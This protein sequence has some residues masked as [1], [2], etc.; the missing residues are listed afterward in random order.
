M[1][2]WFCLFLSVF[3]LAG[4]LA[5]T[6]ARAFAPHMQ[7]PLHTQHDCCP[8]MTGAHQDQMQHGQKH[9]PATSP[10][11]CVAGFCACHGAGP[12]PSRMA[13]ILSATFSIVRFIALSHDDGH[14][15][16]SRPPD[17]RPPIA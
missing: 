8:A 14:I 3:A 7:H 9:D 12:Y 11:C 5:S 4:L 15:G 6:P 13:Q 1:A 2:R 16:Q 10:G 17:L